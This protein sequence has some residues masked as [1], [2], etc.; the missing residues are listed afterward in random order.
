M[1]VKLH[2]GKTLE[3]TEPTE[4]DQIGYLSMLESYHQKKESDG[5]FEAQKQAIQ[6]QNRLL[7]KLTGSSV[8]EVKKMALV[9]K[10][11]ALEAIKGRLVVIGKANHDMDF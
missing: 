5:E 3:V 4:E 10:N 6:T 8:E 2:D 11:K 1:R 9:D 7:A